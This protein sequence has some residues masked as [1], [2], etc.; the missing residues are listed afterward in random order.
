[1]PERPE[2]GL[3]ER[4]KAFVREYLVDLNASAAARRAGYSPKSA[5]Q[6]GAENMKKPGIKAEIQ[7]QMYSRAARTRIDG[8]YVLSAIK[9]IAELAEDREELPAALKGLELLG[10]HLKMFTDKIEHSGQVDIAQKV[11]EARK[12]AGK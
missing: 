11:L 9:R 1:M 6:S 8:D 7:A 12:R 3:N 2:R 5:H 10:K 4:Q